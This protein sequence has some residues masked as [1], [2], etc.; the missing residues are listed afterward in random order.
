MLVALTTTV[1][2]RNDA[3]QLVRLHDFARLLGHRQAVTLKHTLNSEQRIWPTRIQLVEHEPTWLLHSLGQYALTELGGWRTILHDNLC[4]TD[5]V[6]TFDVR[7]EVQSLNGDTK[8]CRNLHRKRRLACACVPMQ[9]DVLAELH[10]RQELDE[11]P[12]AELVCLV[13]LWA[14]RVT[15]DVTVRISPLQCDDIEIQLARLAATLVREQVTGLLHHDLVR[16]L[17]NRAHC[18]CWLGLERCV[19]Q[20]LQLSFKRKLLS[21]SV[22]VVLEY[23]GDAT[24]CAVSRLLE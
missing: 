11:V 8:S 7:V 3:E 15:H 5:H 18:L 23:L 6:S 16:Q 12:H 4:R 24:Q 10:G 14:H 9:P 19:A 2:S 13:H 1:G 21:T 17:A 20:L 22:V